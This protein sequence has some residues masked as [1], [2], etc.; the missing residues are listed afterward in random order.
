VRFTCASAS[1][2]LAGDGRPVRRHPPARGHRVRRRE[3]VLRSP[4]SING[5]G[6]GG[7]G[8]GD[9]RNF[10]GVRRRINWTS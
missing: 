7:G 10:T 2:C 1:A 3:R 8:G 5:G 4:R 9:L 6:E